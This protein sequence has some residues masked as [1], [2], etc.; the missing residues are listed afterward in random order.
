MERL[1]DY[2]KVTEA[3]AFLGVRTF[4]ASA[5]GGAGWDALA[6]DGFERATMLRER[7]PARLEPA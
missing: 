5:T 4:A 7:T 2:L 6:R 1:N 3:A